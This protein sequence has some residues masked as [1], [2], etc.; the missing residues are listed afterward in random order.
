VKIRA[1]TVE[2]FIAA[3]ETL[4]VRGI[5]DENEDDNSII[6]KMGMVSSPATKTTDGTFVG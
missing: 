6:F 5:F 4:E 3:L 1:E 2:M